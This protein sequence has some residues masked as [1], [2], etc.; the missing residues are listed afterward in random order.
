MRMDAYVTPTKDMQWLFV[1]DQTHTSTGY[2]SGTQ[3]LE[4][5]GSDP[6]PFVT[7]PRMLP[8]GHRCCS[9]A[10]PSFKHLN[11]SLL[12]SYCVLYIMSSVSHA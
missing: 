6:I 8:L 4:K 10:S 7:N 2:S 9:L 3:N 11:T 1:R 12:L 5:K